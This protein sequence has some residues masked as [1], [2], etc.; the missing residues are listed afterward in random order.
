MQ[1]ALLNKLQRIAAEGSWS[2]AE[3]FNPCE[4]SGGNYDDAYYGGV[5]DGRIELA[6]E[7]LKDI[8]HGA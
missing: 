7:I 3:D 5:V 6:R 2:D 8:K 4:C 1:E